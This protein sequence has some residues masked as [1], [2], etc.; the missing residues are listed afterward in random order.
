MK[1][2]KAL[3]GVLAAFALV[4]I[5]FAIG[6]EVTLRRLQAEGPGE[7]PGASGPADRVVLYY[8]HPTFRC[9]TC[10]QMEKM[11]QD[12]VQTEFAAP[13]DEGRLQWREVNYE[14]DETLAR[15]YNVATSSLVVVRF[16][17]G[18]EADH[19]ALDRIWPLLDRPDEL[20][21]LVRQAIRSRLEGPAP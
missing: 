9:V 6:K 13:L 5:G 12:L 2:R 1:V 14:E 11:V 4:S 18:E 7:A 8:M 3:A 17:G 10:N 20:K 21:A 16:R 19:E 15:R